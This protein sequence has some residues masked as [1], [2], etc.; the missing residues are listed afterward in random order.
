M[1]DEDPDRIDYLR[2][3]ETFKPDWVSPPGDTIVDLLE[4]HDLFADELMEMLGFT[5]SLQVADL[6]TGRSPVTPEIGKILSEKL[7]GSEGFWRR[8]EKF[9]RWERERLNP[10]SA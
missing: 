3:L 1:S 9:Y 4:Q 6:I 10:P 7:G 5:T 2:G 8:R